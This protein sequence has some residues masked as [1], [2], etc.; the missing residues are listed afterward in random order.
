M[1]EWIQAALLALLVPAW[2]I[3]QWSISTEWHTG[4][5]RVLAVGLILLALCYLSA[6]IGD[7]SDTVRKTLVWIGSIALLPS[8]F[9][10]L[11]IAMEFQNGYSH[12][13]PLSSS[14]SLVSWTIALAAPLLLAWFLRGRAVWINFLWAAW[15]YALVLSAT[16]SR[17][18]ESFRSGSELLST[19]CLYSLCALG[20]LGLVGWGLREKRKERLNLGIAAFAISVLSFYF[21]SFMGKLGRSASLLILGAICLAGGYVL[22]VTRR[23]LISR[24]E[25]HQ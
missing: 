6:R 23:K 5:D 15:A 16:Y 19:L 24:L 21:D 7:E 18:F 2:L 13:T 4:G 11:L 22:E 3:S 20:S 14:M 12:L 8:I 9:I 17:P 1:R 25:A 10:A